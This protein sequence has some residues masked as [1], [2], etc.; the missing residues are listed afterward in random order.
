MTNKEK[1]TSD[2]NKQEISSFGAYTE[3]QLDQFKVEKKQLQKA[4]QE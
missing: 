3:T 1:N 4:Q 2:Q